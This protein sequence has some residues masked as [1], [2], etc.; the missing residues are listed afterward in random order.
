M[1]RDGAARRSDP[2]R[3]DRG[4]A[5]S[6]ARAGRRQS[7][8]LAAAPLDHE[9]DDRRGPA[10]RLGAG[11][12]RAPGKVRLAGDAGAEAAARPRRHRRGGRRR[13]GDERSTSTMPRWSRSPA[14]ACCRSTRLT[15]AGTAVCRWP[16]TRMP[17]ST[18]ARMLADLARSIAALARAR[19]A[20]RVALLR[21]GTQHGR[22]R[23]GARPRQ[24]DGVPGPRPGPAD[25]ARPRSAAGAPRTAR[26]GRRREIRA[27]TFYRLPASPAALARSSCR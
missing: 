10:R 18:A 1:P 5:A 7:A 17:G 16:T 21:A 24:V 23:Q 2:G 9:R 6:C 15:M 8:D 25:V 14:S 20:R 4:V 19:E 26:R 12:D 22:G 13:A 3:A 11:A 27:W